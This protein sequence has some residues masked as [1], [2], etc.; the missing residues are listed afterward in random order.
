MKLLLVSESPTLKPFLERTFSFQQADV[1]HYDNPIKAMDNLGEIQ[2]AVVLFS[3]TDFP[4]HWKPFVIFLRNTFT[5]HEAIFILL[6]NDNFEPDEAE[7]AEYLEVN[8]VLDEDLTTS[9]AVQRIRGIITR[10]HQSVDIRRAARYIPSPGDN[11]RLVFTNPNTFQITAGTVTDISTGGL[12]FRPDS[13]DTF[14]TIDDH[15]MIPMASLRLG[16]IV[17]PVH[18]QV[19][20]VVEQLGLEFYDLSVETEERIAGYLARLADSDLAPLDEGETTES[21]VAQ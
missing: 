10:Y 15:T 4:R 3:A 9:Q 11:V 5:R 7:K 17:L 19:V 8:A 16:E 20:R 14:E 18:L 6:I 2:P 1:I 13:P 21:D 12:R